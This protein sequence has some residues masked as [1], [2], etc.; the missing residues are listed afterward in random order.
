M[1]IRHRVAAIL[2]LQCGKQVFEFLSKREDIELVSVYALN[3]KKSKNIAGFIDFSLFVPKEI[4]H[5]YESLSDIGKSISAL[6]QI[7]VIFAIG[8]S[9]IIKEPILSASRLGCIGVHAAMLPDR[10]G[11]SPVVWAI[12]DGLTETAVTLFRMDKGVDS[13][14]IFDIEKIKIGKFETAG[15]LRK[16]CDTATVRLLERS[17]DGILKEENRGVPQNN[18]PKKYTR[19]RGIEDGE[20]NLSSSAESILRKVNALSSPYPG[21]HFYAGDGYPVIIEKARLGG[22]ELLQYA[23]K[24]KKNIL[25]VVAHP[26]DEAL[27]VGGTLIRHAM[28]G[29]NV[30]IIIVSEGESAK[31][32]DSPA[33]PERLVKAQAW[34]NQTGCKLRACYGFS[35][36]KLDQTPLIEIIHKLEVDISHFQPEVV[37]THH[38]ADMN[39]DH[40]VVSRA[41]LASVRPMNRTTSVNEILAFETPSSTE[42]APNIPQFTFMPTRYV[43]VTRVWQKKILSLDVYVN[44]LRPD[45]HPR[46]VERIKSLAMKRGTESGL[47]LAEAFVVLRQLWRDDHK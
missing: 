45:P 41:V 14:P 27:G 44:E 10:P 43:D 36:Q 35:D 31:S 42:Q 17:L 11:C 3:K 19:K 30:Q 38:P 40:G 4:F 12:L 34:C 8:I 15:Q 39:S 9:E 5:P 13:G 46:S 16:K 32:A 18:S 7:D 20:I 26:D 1:Q 2:G 47:D 33:D 6:R 28:Q 24:S 22:D 23:P 21:A 29:D 25:C 37:Y